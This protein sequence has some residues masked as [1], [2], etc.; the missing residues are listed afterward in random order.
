M[1]QQKR[2]EKESKVKDE[3]SGTRNGS[4]MFP[5]KTAALSHNGTGVETASFLF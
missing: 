4:G 3:T 1:R 2:I 5:E